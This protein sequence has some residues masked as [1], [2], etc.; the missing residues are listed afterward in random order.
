VTP[1]EWWDH[2]DVGPIRVTAVPADHPVR[3]NGYVLTTERARVYVAGDTRYFR[4]MADIATAFPALDVAFL[5]VGGERLVGLK[6]TMDPAEAA[7]AAKLFDPKRIVPIAYGAGGGFPFVW[8][9]GDAVQR[10]REEAHAA[11]VAAGRVVV[12]EPG[13]SWHYYR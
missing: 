6:Q 13:E 5:P 7:K 10:F 11:G 4:E 1:L 2:T 8:Y 3:E 9:T 12:L